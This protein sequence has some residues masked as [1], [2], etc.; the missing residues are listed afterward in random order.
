MV[1][2]HG[3]RRNNGHRQQRDEDRRDGGDDEHREDDQDRQQNRHVPSVAVPA[4]GLQDQVIRT[5]FRDADARQPAVSDL[6]QR[7]IRRPVGSQ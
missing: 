3:Q 1:E 5:C 2:Q 4:L 7:V 6:A